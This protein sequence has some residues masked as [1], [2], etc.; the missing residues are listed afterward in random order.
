MT[1]ERA[2]VRNRNDIIVSVILLVFAAV[3]AIAA[4]RL[5]RAHLA[6]VI[7]ANVYPLVLAALLA[8]LSLILLVRSCRSRQAQTNGWLPTRAIGKQIV[9]LFVAL[10]VY[11]VLFRSVGYLVATIVF[12]AGTL[13]FIDRSRSWLSVALISLLVSAVC[14]ALFVIL[15]QIPVPSG[16]LM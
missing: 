1:G 3:Y 12:M 13:K 11:L 9:F 5:P 4:D 10:I 6:E 8:A 7:E 14:Y 15:F 2:G 16:V